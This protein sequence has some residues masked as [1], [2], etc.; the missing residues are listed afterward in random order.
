VPIGGGVAQQPRD[1]IGQA[2][3]AEQVTHM[4]GLRRQVGLDDVFEQVSLVPVVEVG[5]E[6]RVVHDVGP[7]LDFG[8]EPFVGS[9]ACSRRGL[10]FNPVR[11]A[12]L[13]R[14]FES[15]QQLGG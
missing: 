7:T 9:R 15:R 12:T 8:G 2:E 4:L 13:L 14:R 1:D 10:T 3:P 5:A 11:H 6:G